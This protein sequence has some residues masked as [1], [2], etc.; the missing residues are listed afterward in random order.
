MEE[1]GYAASACAGGLAFLSMEDDHLVYIGPSDGFRSR[2]NSLHALSALLS[3]KASYCHSLFEQGK[4]SE[5]ELNS[6]I[7]SATREAGFVVS[8][9]MSVLE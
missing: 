7:K 5:P 3:I 1:L 2:S 9:L 4:I 6:L 8:E